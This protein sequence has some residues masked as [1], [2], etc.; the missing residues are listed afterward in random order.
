MRLCLLPF[1][2]EEEYSRL[3]EIAGTF[4]NAIAENLY[5]INSVELFSCPQALE[6]VYRINMASNTESRVKILTQIAEHLDVPIIVTGAIKN[7]HTA[8]SL[9]MMIYSERTNEYLEYH[10]DNIEDRFF[11]AIN[12]ILIK[13]S[14]IFSNRI[15]IDVPCTESLEAYIHYFKAVTEFNKND[16]PNQ[17]FWQYSLLAI[18]HDPSFDRVADLIVHKSLAMIKKDGAM[19]AENALKTLISIKPNNLCAMFA[20][21][22]F[23]RARSDHDETIQLMQS[24]L[25]KFPHYTDGIFRLASYYHS[26]N[27]YAEA[28]ETLNK[29]NVF[30]FNASHLH[31]QGSIMDSCGRCYEALLAW[32]NALQIDPSRTC[33]LVCMASLMEKMGDFAHAQAYHLLSLIASPEWHNYYQYGLFLERR[34]DFAAAKSILDR[35]IDEQP[36]QGVCY[37]QIGRLLL[38][39]GEVDNAQTMFLKALRLEKNI[40]IQQEIFVQIY[41]HDSQEEMMM[42]RINRFINRRSLIYAFLALMY[43]F[44]S[45]TSNSQI[46]WITGHFLETEGFLR[47]ATLAY[48]KAFMLEPK[49]GKHAKSLGTILVRKKRKAGY[50][51]LRIAFSQWPW[52]L[53]IRKLLKGREMQ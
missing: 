33:L 49:S 16:R 48:Y 53:E 52:D 24:I 13:I 26:I 17:L 36:E 3:S 22:E 51:Y 19:L 31:L 40:E 37:Y 12:D 42:K 32:K 43:N 39:L 41:N 47:F 8:I 18:A 29:I 4:M 34:G 15:V 45:T 20:L 50:K 7:N 10:W 21:A 46:W 28:L 30:A 38:K 27:R 1:Y 23:A 9:V 5:T 2:Q 25:Q 11:S 35:V 6:T 14:Q 44:F